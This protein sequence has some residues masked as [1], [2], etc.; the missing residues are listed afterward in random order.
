MSG[1]KLIYSIKSFMRKRVVRVVA[2]CF[3]LSIVSFCVYSQS[4]PFPSVSLKVGAASG[5]KDVALTLQV[6]FLLTVLTLAPAFIIM[7]TSFTRIVIV[8]AFIRQ[9]M[10]TQQIPPN[11]VIIA[12]AL[13]LTFFVMTPVING[14]NNDALQPYLKGEISQAAAVEEGWGY[15]KNF[16]IR[17]TRPNDLA[18]FVHLS[19]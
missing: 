13:F 12:L 15:I 17:Q 10:A 9:A 19:K 14:V 6:L 5:A 1:A 11:Q 4:I 8:L 7:V 18:L 2:V 3:G 16:M